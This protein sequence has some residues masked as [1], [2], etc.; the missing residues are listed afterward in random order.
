MAP[1]KLSAAVVRA[2][3]SLM[4]GRD[5]LSKRST[6]KRLGVSEAGLRKAL[7]R[8]GKRHRKETRGRKKAL[9]DV[10]RRKIFR[11]L[12]KENRKGY[13]P[14]APWIR[15]RLRL[16]CSTSTVRREIKKKKYK[17]KA[18]QAFFKFL[19]IFGLG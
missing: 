2:A 19:K 6:A 10:Q 18:G 9:T 12:N 8:K 11:L 5:G 14:D 15:R 17:Y 16:P 3:R 1:P 13:K 4:K 7:A